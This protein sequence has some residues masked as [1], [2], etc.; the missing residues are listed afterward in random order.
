MPL[1]EKPL[2]QIMAEETIQA[3]PDP[4]SAQ[5]M[6]DF[7]LSRYPKFKDSSVRAHL[8][9]MSVNDPNKKHYSLRRD[10]FFKLGRSLYR[11]YEAERDGIYDDE[12]KPVA[13]SSAIDV[14]DEEEGI[15]SRWTDGPS[16]SY[17]D[18]RDRFSL[19][20]WSKW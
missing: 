15:E 10:V 8:R 18:R 3:L 11:R 19:Q 20:R 1:Y 12:G 2:V 13:G 17:R 6:I 7:V 16:I 9:A 4:F 14:D 5:Q